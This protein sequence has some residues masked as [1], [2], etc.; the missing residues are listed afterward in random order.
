MTEQDVKLQKEK[1]RKEFFEKL[2]SLDKGSYTTLR[3]SCGKT[4]S[5][6]GAE[7]TLLFFRLLPKDVTSREMNRWFL[8]ACAF[9]LWDQGTRGR[10]PMPKAFAKYQKSEGT[11]SFQSRFATLLDTPWTE[12]GFF[13][14]KLTRLLKALKAKGYA[15][16]ANDLLMSLLGWNNDS[17]SV[18][19]IWAQSF[20]YTLYHKEEEKNAD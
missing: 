1:E 2:D 12:D 3:R 14:S 6:A 8:A 18:Q 9:C 16:D 10:I 15:V 19:I 17:R 11:D 4:L 7:A 20:E 5:D 13:S